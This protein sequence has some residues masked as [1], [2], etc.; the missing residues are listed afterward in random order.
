MNNKLDILAI[1]ETWL[2]PSIPS[3][4]VA[5]CNYNLIRGDTSSN[6]RK[7]GA[8]LYIHKDIKF[9]NFDTPLPNVVAVQLV[10]FGL[11]VVACYR[12]PSYTCVSNSNL[13]SFLSEFCFG[14]EVVILGDFN[15]PSLR[16][17]DNLIGYISPVDLEFLNCFSF[18]GLHQWVEEATIGS[19]NILD[20]VLTSESDRVSAV[21]VLPPLP[22]CAHYPVIISYSFCRD[23]AGVA[24]PC[25]KRLW[26]RGKYKRISEALSH[27]DWERELMYYTVEDSYNFLLSVLQPL[28]ERFVPE[29]LPST[30]PP[31]NIKVPADLLQRRGASWAN[32]KV[33]RQQHGRGSAPA[34][35]ALNEFNQLNY[36]YRNFVLTS[37]IRY[38][39]NLL[40]RVDLRK[41]FHAYIRSKKVGR[42]S[43]GPLALP[44]GEFVDDPGLM[45]ETFVTSFS[46]VFVP[47]VPVDP[48]P[49]QHF[50]GSLP[51]V[52]FSREVVRKVLSALDPS[53]SMGPDGVHPYLLKSCAKELS[54]PLSIIFGKSMNT[55]TIPGLWSSSSVIPIFKSK[56]HSDPLNY[57]PVSLTSVCCKSM[58]RIVAADLMNYLEVNGL[59]SQHQYGFRKDRSVEDQLLLAYDYI[60]GDVNRG[61][62]VDV[63]F[64]DFSKAF[65]VVSHSVLLTKLSALGVCDGLLCWISAFISNRVMSVCVNGHQS[66]QVEVTSGVPQG[67]VL[68]P[69]LFLIYVNHITSGLQCQYKAFADDYKLYFQFPVKC[70]GSAYHGVWRLQDSLNRVDFVSRSW[71]LKL[72]TDKCVCMRF[73]RSVRVVGD[74]RESPYLLQGVALKY[75]D[76]YKDLGVWVDSSLRFHQHTRVIAAKAGGLASNMLRSTVC[77]EPSFM[78]SLFVSHIRP[79]ID[80]CSCAW[81]TGYIS[82][83]KLLES[84]QRR[85]TKKVNGLSEMN[86]GD[87]LRRLNL[88]S[89]KGRLLRADLI[90]YW[91]ILHGNNE[92][93]RGLF[94]FA[95]AV[96]TRGHLFKL[97]ASI[98]L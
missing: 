54:I 94:S 10:E 6:V 45:A 78:V 63:I 87:R 93:M 56:V 37:R 11:Y 67:S 27:V 57:R 20:L 53:S 2:I 60:T 46:S 50:E 71:N 64:L 16:W 18:L 19:G 47:A 1:S 95:P 89:I 29:K 98:K 61:L 65:D 86:Y 55:G 36:T 26:H 52:S 82:D 48:E 38:E 91:K 69:I 84:V 34:S 92:E 41:L 76:S 97:A 8:L 85:W 23:V 88:F 12:P 35:A 68:G 15:L 44:G 13:L 58:E 70:G 39:T 80:Y 30:L 62:P 14:K 17:S 32:Y 51:T 31:W 90:K 66:R 75:V 4:F 33:I 3:S 7:H 96:G 22:R 9:L 21:S 74:G 77:R 49:H 79:L 40:E 72:N 42:P 83:H 43:V 73:G 24:R 81:N 59:L 5:I 28:V 25:K